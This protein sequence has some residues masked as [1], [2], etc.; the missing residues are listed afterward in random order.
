MRGAIDSQLLQSRAD[1]LS[2]LFNSSLGYG[3]EVLGAITP[4]QLHASYSFAGQLKLLVDDY[5]LTVYQMSR[6]SGQQAPWTDHLK[7]TTVESAKLPAVENKHV[8]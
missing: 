2:V 4:N 7:S 1:K 5:P 3:N 6:L 8:I